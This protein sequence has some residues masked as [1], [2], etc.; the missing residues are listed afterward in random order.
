MIVPLSVNRFPSKLVPNVP[1]NIFRNPPVCSFAYIWTVSLT[2]FIN[3][4]DSSRDLTNLIIS[5]ISSSKIINVVVYE[6]NICG[7]PNPNFF[8]QIVASVADDLAVNPNDIKTLL[9][10]GLSLFLIKGNPVFN[11]VPKLLP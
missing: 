11:N 5:F 4:T 10:N 2:L 9:A 8:L 6:A 3:K 1:N 7:R